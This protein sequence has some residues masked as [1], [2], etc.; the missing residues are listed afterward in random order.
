MADEGGR[1]GFCIVL[2]I[3]E[4]VEQNAPQ[5][6][7]K[8]MGGGE[9]GEDEDVA[10]WVGGVAQKGGGDEEGGDEVRSGGIAEDAPDAP[11]FEAQR[12][13]GV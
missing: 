2:P 8:G 9:S 4:L 3:P 11:F 13:G 10:G 1:V 6:Y 12:W 5:P 7:E